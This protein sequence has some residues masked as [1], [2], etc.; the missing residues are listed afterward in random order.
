MD[1][2][3][4]H[5][6]DPVEILRAAYVDMYVAPANSGASEGVRGPHVIVVRIIPA[7][8]RVKVEP[9]RIELRAHVIYEPVRVAAPVGCSH[10]ARRQWRLCRFRSI[11]LPRFRG[12]SWLCARAITANVREVAWPLVIILA[13]GGGVSLPAPSKMLIRAVQ[14]LNCSRSHFRRLPFSGLSNALAA[15]PNSADCDGVRARGSAVMCGQIVEDEPKQSPN[16]PVK[17]L[18]A[19]EAALAGVLSSGERQPAGMQPAR[20]LRRSGCPLR[21]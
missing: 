1:I 3:I 14:E 6:G 15:A 7:P 17:D 12:H 4:V 2:L 11:E 18:T 16:D 8:R 19:E 13:R 5:F 21:V 20:A 10:K 9:V